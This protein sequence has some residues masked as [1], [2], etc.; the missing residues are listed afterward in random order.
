MRAHPGD[1]EFF[2]AVRL[3]LLI[4]SER[5]AGGALRRARAGGGA[6]CHAT[7]HC[8]SRRARSTRIDWTWRDAAEWSVNFMGLAGP[9]GR[10]PLRLLGIDRGSHPESRPGAGGVPR[11]FNHRMISLFY[12]AWEK[13]RFPVAY[14]RDGKDRLS[15]YLMSVDRPGDAGLAEAA[16]GAG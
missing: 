10:A 6:I 1:F 3:L 4:Y 7:R 15:R 2:Q 9:V 5:R 16:G 13:Y 14:E 12:Q 8:P 11:I